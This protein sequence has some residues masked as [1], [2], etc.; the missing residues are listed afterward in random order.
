MVDLVIRGGTVVDGSGDPRAAGD[1][2]VSGGR[3]AAVGRVEDRGRRE[4]DAAGLVVCPG[5]IDLHTH[6]DAQYTWDPYATSSIWHGVTTTVIGNC[7]FAIAPCRPQDRDVTLRT[8]V[9]VEGM[10]L[11][12]MRAGITWQFETFPEYLAHLERGNPSLNVAA[13]LGHSSARR[14]VMGADC[15]YRTA[16]DEEVARMADLVREAMAAGAIGFGSS[17]AEAHVGE[18]GLPVPSR[19]ADLRELKALTRAMGESGRGV[20]EITVGDKTTMEDLRDIYRESGRPV[21]WAAFFHRDD[22]PDYTTDRL[23]WTE[24]FARDGIEVRPQVSPRPLTM[25]F[26]MHN[27]YPFEGM[28][29]WQRVITRP[30]AEWAQVYAD[31][32]FRDAL[33]ADVTARRFSVFRGQWDMIRVLRAG[34]PELRRWVGM[35]LAE[36]AA[37]T[38]KDV[39]DAWLDLVLADDLQTEFLAGIMN[40][41]EAVVGDLVAHPRTLVSLSDAGAHL[42]LLCDAGYS[43]TLLGKWVRERR[44]LSLEAAVRRL[45]ADPAQAYRIPGRGLLRPGAWA[46]IVVFDPETVDAEAPEW[47]HD[48][49]EGEPRFISRA[50]G[51]V[52]SLVNGVPVLERG[53]VI[54]RPP[55]ERPGQVLRRF[56]A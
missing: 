4:I 12:A 49:P 3:I 24:A 54:E 32:G 5:F 46:D 47:V 6:Y 15:Q 17:T 45:T 42:S 13:L 30:E 2:A 52:W 48:L 39:V 33:R 20:F 56:D 38:G 8:L 44:R 31:P 26:T 21:V 7:G 25:D 37:E 51:I 19:L 41:N 29:A 28:Q 36:I 16:T 55:G 22:R 27:P 14:W 11:R 18:G 10:S 23:A 34:K 50:R 35:N 1:V 9:K 40:S 43:T 53:Q